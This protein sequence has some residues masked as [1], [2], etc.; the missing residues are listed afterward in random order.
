MVGYES[1]EGLKG[2]V[3]FRYLVLNE[4]SKLPDATLLEQKNGKSLYRRN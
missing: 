2:G 4:N 1:A 3:G